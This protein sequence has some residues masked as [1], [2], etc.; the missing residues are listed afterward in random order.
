M[1]TKMTWRSLIFTLS[2]LI[3]SACSSNGIT[4]KLVHTNPPS[5]TQPT[6]L[7]AHRY[8]IEAQQSQGDQKLNW[9]LLAAK[10][11]L[12]EG[13][14]AQAHQLLTQIKPKITSHRQQAAWRLVSAYSAQLNQHDEQAIEFLDISSDWSL[15]KDYW[16]AIYQRQAELYHDNHQN[17]EG[18]KALIKLEKYVAKDQQQAI[19]KKIW[20]RLKP[21]DSFQLRSYQQPGHPVLNG[22]LELIAISNEPVKNPQQLL[23]KLNQWKES[24]PDHPAAHFIQ[25]SLSEVLKRK[26]YTPK[27]ISILLPLSGHFAKSGNWIRNGIIAAYNDLPTTTDHKP[28]LNFIDTNAQPMVTL[29]QQIRSSQTDF[30][31]G[32]LLQPNIDAYQKLNVDL[33]WLALNDVTV[34]D[35]SSTAN[36]SL[37]LEPETQA[38]QAAQQISSQG[39]YHPLVLVPNNP[40]GKR[41]AQSFNKQW[42]TTHNDP[43]NITY[44]QDQ[45]D[46]QKAVQRMLLLPESK[47]RIHKMRRI[48]GYSIKTEP[49]SRRDSNS[50]YIVANNLQSKL[51]IPFINV[52]ISPF[53]EPLHLFGS[54]RSYQ[55]GVNNHDLNGMMLTMTPWLLDKTSDHVKRFNQLWPHASNS[56]RRLYALGYDSYHILPHLAQMR[57]FKDYHLQGLTGILSVKQNGDVHRQLVWSRYNDGYLES[58][59]DQ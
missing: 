5:I 18:A 36:Y 10:A 29:V 13:H 27:N 46:L 30:V 57:G 4:P 41:M 7:S 54:S 6:E 37:S 59:F 48:L 25:G 45:Q 19:E 20:Q 39:D 3:L 44:Y 56:A 2:T 16:Q 1:N 22:Y 40:I 47:Q 21:M 35:S 11:Y 58:I 31:I 52:S 23:T 9:Q 17:V 26:L 14:L 28:Q 33:P 50:V 24:Y 34:T 15:P 32:P 43:I 55:S 53:A 49:R 51:I 12:T 8:L 42:L 38:I